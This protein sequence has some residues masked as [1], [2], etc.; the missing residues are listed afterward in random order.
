[1]PCL[2][3]ASP[4]PPYPPLWTSRFIAQSPQAPYVTTDD[5]YIAIIIKRSKCLVFHHQKETSQSPLHVIQRLFLQSLCLF[6]CPSVL[7][8]HPHTHAASSEEDGKTFSISSLAVSSG[9]R[10]LQLRCQ[11]TDSRPG[12]MCEYV[13]RKSIGSCPAPYLGQV[14][15]TVL[16]LL[17]VSS[18]PQFTVAAVRQEVFSWPG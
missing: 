6:A 9:H 11:R 14:T 15:R 8:S 10:L 3:R 17:S 4:S 12:Q 5:L 16:R 18:S 13:I 1:M 2:I 7:T